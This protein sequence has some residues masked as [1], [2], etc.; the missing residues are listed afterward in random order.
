MDPSHPP[1][2]PTTNTRRQCLS[3]YRRKEQGAPG[4]LNLPGQQ[5]CRPL[6]YD[7][8]Y[9]V[10]PNQHSPTRPLWINECIPG[11]LRVQSIVHRNLRISDKI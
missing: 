5:S 6:Q 11:R 1:L 8:L 2:P 9:R 10:R 7:I 4:L 3:I